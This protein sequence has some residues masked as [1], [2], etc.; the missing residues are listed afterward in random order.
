MGNCC[1]REE[2]RA[3]YET[4]HLQESVSPRLGD[5]IQCKYSTLGYTIEKCTLMPDSDN[6]LQIVTNNN[7][8]F[9]NLAEGLRTKKIEELP[10]AQVVKKGRIMINLL[11]HEIHCVQELDQK[12]IKLIEQGLHQ[13]WDFL[14]QV[15]DKYNFSARPFESASTKPI[16]D[17][18]HLIHTLDEGY[19]SFDDDD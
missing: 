15:S 1:I 17:L 14:N 5:G 8:I 4:V 10:M 12:R 18:S 3:D 11:M 2:P 16:A 19:D 13:W 6:L 7:T 9:I